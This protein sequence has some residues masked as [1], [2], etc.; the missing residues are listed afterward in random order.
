MSKPIHPLALFRLM[1]LGP[2]ASR[3]ELTR[4][5]IKSVINAL[6]EKSY[7]IP[8][9][10]RCRL[11]PE[12]IQRWYYDWKRGGIDALVP[13]TRT[14]CGKT[15]LPTHIADL[16]IACKRDN[17][18]RS[19][20]SL[21]HL[22]EQQGAV[23]K[24][25]LSRAS[26]HRFLQQNKLSQRMP[27]NL[28]TIERRAFVAEHAGD[29]WHGDVMHGPSIQTER[30]IRK[31]YLVSLM[32]DASRFI[33][34]SAFCFG[35]TALDV[36]GVL[37]Q[38]VLKY[39]LPHR[40]IIDNGA[41]YRAKSLQDICARL[42]I[43]LI[44]CRPYEPE[45]KGKLERFH[46][47][48]RDQFMTEIFPEKIN[49]IDDLNVRLWAWLEQIYHARPHGGLEKTTPRDRFRCDLLHIRTLGF[50]AEKIDDLFNHRIERTVRR[51]GTIHWNGI[52][53]EVK[54]GLVD[55]EIIL[56][57]DPH[58]N[59]AVRAESVFG[60]DYGAVVMLDPRANLHR[61]RHRPAPPVVS[62]PAKNTSVVDLALQ[63][64]QQSFNV[65]Y[66]N[67]EK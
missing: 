57:V 54:H 26:V 16:I 20:R 23:A 5:E 49:G 25:T 66:K 62:D 28:T 1:V 9:S 2:L 43:R 41:A 33:V 34:H 10:R 65:L 35:E 64:Y 58:T 19:I 60:D 27:P 39:G 17:P 67:Q 31:T 45:A 44:Y 63:E 61:K 8:N 11:S 14:D 18:A 32:D 55:R 4:G 29:I 3:S 38:A 15:R 12:T 40:L 47:T 7:D 59:T 46:R 37:K 36:E 22:I 30:G 50:R 6:A 51:D 52:K 48:F 42:E 56:V 53:F 21:I 24:S 13:K